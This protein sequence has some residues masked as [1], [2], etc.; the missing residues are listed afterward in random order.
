MAPRRAVRNA[1]I[2]AS[3]AVTAW[4]S[5]VSERSQSTNRSPAP[6]ASSPSSNRPSGGS[7]WPISSL[8]MHTAM[9]VRSVGTPGPTWRSAGRTKA[10]GSSAP[11]RIASPT[12]ALAALSAVQ[13]AVPAK[14]ANNSSLHA[15]QPPGA[16]TSVA[17]QSSTTVSDRASRTKPRRRWCKMD[18]AMSSLKF[19]RWCAAHAARTRSRYPG[20]AG[21]APQGGLRA[22]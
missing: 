7:T 17:S 3:S 2:A 21:A 10:G 9:A 4:G 20:T 16:S 12:T 11:S 5:A 6:A 14:Q 18:T 19:W 22:I 8:R 15:V 1:T 13:G